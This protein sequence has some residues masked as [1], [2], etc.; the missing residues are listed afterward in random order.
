MRAAVFRLLDVTSFDGRTQATS[1]H[2][3]SLLVIRLSRCAHC[4]V[5]NSLVAYTT[6]AAYAVADADVARPVMEL[7]GI[8]SVD[9]SSNADPT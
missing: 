2:L 1:A 5:F 8:G 9:G 3:G 6:P 4:L 7:V